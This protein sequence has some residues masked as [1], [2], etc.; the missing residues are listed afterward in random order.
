MK[1]NDTLFNISPAVEV[2]YDLHLVAALMRAIRSSEPDVKLLLHAQAFAALIEKEPDGPDR[3]NDGIPLDALLFDRALL[4][5]KSKQS[6]IGRHLP[7]SSQLALVTDYVRTKGNPWD[8]GKRMALMVRRGCE[9]AEDYINLMNSLDSGS[10]DLWQAIVDQKLH[11]RI[12]FAPDAD[13]APEAKQALLEPTGPRMVDP[14]DGDLL[15]V[16]FPFASHLNKALRT[17]VLWKNILPARHYVCLLDTLLRLHAFTE[18]HHLALVNIKLFDILKKAQQGANFTESK[19]RNEFDH[20]GLGMLSTGSNLLDLARG[21]SMQF[22]C[23]RIFFGS[24]HDLDGRMGSLAQLAVWCDDIRNGRDTQ[25]T[26]AMDRYFKDQASGALDQSLSKS[27]SRKNFEEFYR[28]VISQRITATGTDGQFDQ[29]YWARKDGD[30][31]RARWKVT[32]SPVGAMLF[33]GLAADGFQSCSFRDINDQLRSAGLILDR[34][35]REELYQLLKGLGLAVDSPD[36]DGGFLVR[37]PFF[38]QKS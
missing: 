1:Y 18:V 22:E 3:W 13:L 31:R 5:P 17:M 28:Y 19:L 38:A 7:I 11:D 24:L 10:K 37:N 35:T 14:G 34:S 32:I 12:A 2:A 30:H 16:L 25:V 9:S 8:V 23:S 15:P 29:G 4:A 36:G 6:Q 20:V 33:A 27:R 21:V 26:D